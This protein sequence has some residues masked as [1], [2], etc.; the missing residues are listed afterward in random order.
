[1]VHVREDG[2]GGGAKNI[3]LDELLYLNNADN[4]AIFQRNLVMCLSVSNNNNN[5]IVC[6][7]VEENKCLGQ[8]NYYSPHRMCN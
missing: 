7:A 3:F 1:M 8:G 4:V 5:N 2:G 6:M